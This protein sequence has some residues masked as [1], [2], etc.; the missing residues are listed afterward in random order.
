M[1]PGR[2]PCETK[3]GDSP[4]FVEP[5]ATPSRDVTPLRFCWYLTDNSSRFDNGWWTKGI[6]VAAFTCAATF[7]SLGFQSL[8]THND[9]SWRKF[10]LHGCAIVCVFAASIATAQVK[11]H[12]NSLPRMAMR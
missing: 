8:E 4:R 9:M 6:A 10:V 2:G 3:R 11:G 7:E 1:R 5:R 12:P